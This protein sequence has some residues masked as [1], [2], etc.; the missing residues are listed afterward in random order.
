AHYVSWGAP[1]A[2]PASQSVTLVMYVDAGQ[3][4]REYQIGGNSQS[5]IERA[6]AP[7][8]YVSNPNVNTITTDFNDYLIPPK[9]APSNPAISV[10]MSGKS[11]ANSATGSS[12]SKSNSNE[13]L[14]TEHE[15][16]PSLLAVRTALTD[17]T[18]LS[19]NT[20]RDASSTPSL[21]A[22]ARDIALQDFVPRAPLIS[23]STS[24]DQVNTGPLGSDTTSDVDGF[25]QTSGDSTGND[26]LGS[27]DVV[28]RE[29]DAV[30]KVL[31]ALHDV[32]VHSM[33]D[34]AGST[35]D[36]VRSGAQ[37][38]D[39]DQIDV[40]TDIAG[41]ELPAGE[42]DG[43]MVLLQSK[44]DAYNNQIDLTTRYARQLQKMAAPV[45]MDASV[46][47]YEALDVAADEVPLTNYNPS[48]G[49]TGEM[50]H[51]N[52]VSE[53][54]PAPAISSAHKA[55]AIIGATTLTGA[56]IWMNHQRK[57][58]HENSAIECS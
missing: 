40:P 14:T 30:H 55:A 18:A 20:V 36:S 38:A 17:F 6:T 50:P 42:V 48:I 49:A 23:V 58:D 10:G 21:S 53:N 29:R 41:N 13:Y 57:R 5:I 37:D 28:A 19:A 52:S 44:G 45:G 4:A 15:Y 33:T 56:L 46:G 43:G 7:I 25:I 27:I 8:G 9:G 16:S 32:D 11:T 31:R 3:R 34:Q 54:I 12:L 51:E 47:I 22:T 1:V 26:V 2:G 39:N 35:P 24:Y